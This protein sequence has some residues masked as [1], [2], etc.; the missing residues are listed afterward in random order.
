MDPVTGKSKIA[1]TVRIV[2][3]EKD[4]GAWAAKCANMTKGV[5]KRF[6]KNG[7]GKKDDFDKSAKCDITHRTAG[8]RGL[9]RLFTLSV[10]DTGLAA[11]ILSGAVPTNARWLIR[12]MTVPCGAEVTITYDGVPRKFNAANMPN[13]LACKRKD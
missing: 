3:A 1:M 2:Y 11:G 7:V 4:I 5:R 9:Q 12:Q 6:T 8:D 10:A 13:P